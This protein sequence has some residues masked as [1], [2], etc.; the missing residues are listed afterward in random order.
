V[1]GYAQIPY[2]RE[3]D[4]NPLIQKER[5]H[6][7]TESEKSKIYDYFDDYYRVKAEN[8]EAHDDHV[9]IVRFLDNLTYMVLSYIE[10]LEQKPGKASEDAID[11]IEHQYDSLMKNFFA[12]EATFKGEGLLATISTGFT[13]ALN[14]INIE[15]LQKKEK[16]ALGIIR[17]YSQRFKEAKATQKNLSVLHTATKLQEKLNQQATATQEFLLRGIKTIPTSEG[18]KPISTPEGK[19]LALSSM[20]EGVDGRSVEDVDITFDTD[21]LGKVVKHYASKLQDFFPRVEMGNEAGKGKTFD[22]HFED[23]SIDVSVEDRVNKIISANRQLKI[24]K[25]TKNLA[26]EVAGILNSFNIAYALQTDLLENLKEYGSSGMLATGELEFRQENVLSAYKNANEKLKELVAE[27]KAIFFPDPDLAK[28]TGQKDIPEAVCNLFGL[29][30]FSQVILAKDMTLPEAMA[31]YETDIKK[32]EE[33]L[34]QKIQIIKDDDKTEKVKAFVLNAGSYMAELAMICAR[35]PSLHQKINS[36]VKNSNPTKEAE[37]RLTTLNDKIKQITLI[38]SQYVEFQHAYSEL[39]DENIIKIKDPK[40]NQEIKIDLGV[41][42]KNFLADADLLNFNDFKDH[43]SALVQLEKAK[44]ALKE[45]ESVTKHL[46]TIAPKLAGRYLSDTQSKLIALKKNLETYTKEYKFSKQNEEMYNQVIDITMKNNAALDTELADIKALASE[47]KNDKQ[48]L[49]DKVKKITKETDELKVTLS[50]SEKNVAE[51]TTIITKL[52]NINKSTIEVTTNFTAGLLGVLKE[53]LEDQISELT[54]IENQLK[55]ENILPETKEKL[56]GQINAIKISMDKTYSRAEQKVNEFENSL[57]ENNQAN[58]A[59]LQEARSILGELSALLAQAQNKVVKLEAEIVDL[60]NKLKAH[61]EKIAQLEQKSSNADEIN[62]TLQEQLTQMQAQLLAAK[63]Q[64]SPEEMA[65]I[66]IK[67]DVMKFMDR[68]IADGNKRYAEKSKMLALQSIKDAILRSVTASPNND[69]NETLKKQLEAFLI[70]CMQKRSSATMFS[71]TTTTG[72][73]A[74]KLLK[75]SHHNTVT[76]LITSHL[77][78]GNGNTPLSYKVL[79]EDLVL[80]DTNHQAAREL[81][82]TEMN[83]KATKAKDR[84]TTN[85]LT[86]QIR[87]PH[88]K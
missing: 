6:K 45:L 77:N 80:N 41:M 76:Q 82:V 59:A 25:K 52:E 73:Y 68:V 87:R 54:N 85:D 86:I 70:I 9:M 17:G 5:T 35:D 14:A 53:G 57:G 11:A 12:K 63:A 78:H 16:L 75:E 8:N 18:A 4:N 38:K 51:L 55:G 61:Q 33:A 74:I 69:F 47:L 88:F 37:G 56:K 22:K 21:L 65:N 1:G 43:A 72:T 20:A 31:G 32:F 64:T 83:S 60:E 66:N 84:I 7:G 19:H 44:H 62:K 39:K 27:R 48:E 29:E 58:K 13:Q 67:A 24:D 40:T 79:V 34:K 2:L 15:R 26:I 28:K 10:I 50:G 71:P 30:K 3:T 42:L 23:G 36:D 49:D 81:A 46:E